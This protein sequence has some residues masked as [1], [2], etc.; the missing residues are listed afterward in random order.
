MR[1][2]KLRIVM[3]AVHSRTGRALLLSFAG[4]EVVELTRVYSQRSKTTSLRENK[5][6]IIA[7]HSECNAQI[8]FKGK[9]KH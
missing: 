2:G 1:E 5:E 3:K 6:N 8:L 9:M 7:P 4:G